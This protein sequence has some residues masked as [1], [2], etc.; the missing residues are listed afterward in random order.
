MSP[1]NCRVF[2]A[3]PGAGDREAAAR[4]RDCVHVTGAEHICRAIAA[5]RGA[6]QDLAGK[7]GVVAVPVPL[8]PVGYGMAPAWAT[9]PM[10][11]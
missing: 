2:V 6:D 1:P 7:L 4:S 5:A 11:A 9:M 3:T 10:T 8:T